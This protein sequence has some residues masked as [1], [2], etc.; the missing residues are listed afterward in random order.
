MVTALA[1]PLYVMLGVL[2]VAGMAKLFRPAATAGALRVMH[3]PAPV[4]TTRLLGA[5]EIALGVTSVL[6]GWALLWALVAALYV[7]FALFVLWALQ[8]DDI[9]SCGCFGQED[10]PPTPG[11]AAF[12][13]A[14]AA[15]AVLAIFEPVR[16][17][18]FDGSAVEA[19]LFVTLI[20]AGVALSVLALTELPRLLAIANGTATPSVAS[21]SVSNA[22]TKSISEPMEPS[23]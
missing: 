6:L 23:P 4:Y 5:A 22:L 8:A 14:A 7:A 11:H 19:V 18:D 21:F 10:T 12:N 15:I 20:V 9:G 13:G 2:V 17:G 3:V 1:G 16:I